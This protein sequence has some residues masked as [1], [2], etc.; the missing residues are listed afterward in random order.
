MTLLTGMSLLKLFFIIS[1]F[2]LVN[3]SSVHDDVEE[4]TGGSARVMEQ[5]GDFTYTKTESSFDRTVEPAFGED[6]LVTP[7]AIWTAK[8]GNGIV[9]CELLL[10]K[11]FK[12]VAIFSKIKRI[13]VDFLKRISGQSKWNIN[14]YSRIRFILRT[15]K[16]SFKLKINKVI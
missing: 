9:L 16:Y 12:G 1:V 14:F 13:K 15:I 5:E 7:P 10:Y 11:G 3:L 4:V 8:T 2:S 6:P